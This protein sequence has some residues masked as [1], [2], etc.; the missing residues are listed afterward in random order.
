MRISD[1]GC[2]FSSLFHFVFL[3]DLFDLA[4]LQLAAA[5]G[6]GRSPNGTH[7]VAPASPFL[8]ALAEAAAVT[9]GGKKSSLKASKGAKGAGGNN[10]DDADA[11]GTAT[12]GTMDDDNEEDENEANDA[13]DNME[14][15]DDANN[16]NVEV[17]TEILSE[18]F[19]I[20]FFAGT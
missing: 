8:T 20:T 9:A 2:P 1:S 18:N 3:Y 7:L 15:A 19:C 6:I 17:R 4:D 14:D 16:D 11:G 10:H 12:A 5:T 13:D